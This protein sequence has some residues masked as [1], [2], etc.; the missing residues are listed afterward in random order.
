MSLG[1][2]IGRLSNWKFSRL[3]WHVP[4]CLLSAIYFT[5]SCYPQSASNAGPCATRFTKVGDLLD[6]G[7]CQQAWNEIWRHAADGNYCAVYEVAMS[8]AAHPFKMSG[9]SP[10]EIRKVFLPSVFYAALASGTEEERQFIRGTVAPGVLEVLAADI[11][12]DKSKELDCLKSKASPDV[13]VKMAVDDHLIPTYDEYIRT[14]QEINRSHLRVSC[15]PT[16][17]GLPRK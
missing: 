5:G 16:T 14:V 3:K 6:R 8:L 2:R 7:Q 15:Q 17:E 4:L 9:A 1:L 13:C 12:Q 10:D 11:Q